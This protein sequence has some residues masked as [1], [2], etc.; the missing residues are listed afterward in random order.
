VFRGSATAEC[1]QLH[2]HHRLRASP[3]P[4]GT[5]HPLHRRSTRCT[6]P[7]TNRSTVPSLVHRSTDPPL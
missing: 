3:A 1:E 7:R 5:T 6:E 4:P 2:Q